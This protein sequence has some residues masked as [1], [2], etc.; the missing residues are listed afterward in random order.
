MPVMGRAWSAC[1][2]DSRPWIVSR[3]A[4]CGNAVGRRGS[5]KSFGS[6]CERRAVGMRPR[7]CP[8]EPRKR[9]KEPRKRPP[10]DSPP[11]VSSPRGE[12]VGSGGERRVAGFQEAVEIFA[13]NTCAGPGARRGSA[14]GRNGHPSRNRSARLLRFPHR[15]TSARASLRNTRR[16]GISPFLAEG[17][18][19]SEQVRVGASQGGLRGSGGP[20]GNAPRVRCRAGFPRGLTLL[21]AALGGQE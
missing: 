2:V 17:P 9:A 8:K 14:G 12:S 5:Q 6:G 20:H 13:Q 16:R 3:F 1:R 4:R 21:C 7:K 11:V 10:V 15:P 18:S 19:E